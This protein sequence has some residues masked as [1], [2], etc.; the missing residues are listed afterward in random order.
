M[1]RVALARA[2]GLCMGL[3]RGGDTTPHRGLLAAEADLPFRAGVDDI[4]CRQVSW[5]T[6]H[7]RR[8]SSQDPLSQ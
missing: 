4:R 2:R 5:L 1:A 8:P 7:R 6:D 3:L